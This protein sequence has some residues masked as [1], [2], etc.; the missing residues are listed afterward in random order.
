MSSQR[1]TTVLT[2]GVIALAGIFSFSLPDSLLPTSKGM[3]Q[4]G[5]PTLYVH[6]IVRD[7]KAD[8][9]D[10]DTTPGNGNGHY[11]GNIATTLDADNKPVFTGGGFKVDTQW[12]EG[13]NNKKICYTLYDAALGDTLG[14][15]GAPD[16]GGITSAETFAQWYRDV[17][18]V[19]MS[20]TY[21]FVATLQGD[22]TYAY[23]TNDFYPIDDQLLGNESESH[24]FY[25]TL[26]IVGTFVYDA[27]A[28]YTFHFKGDDD[29]WVFINGQLVVDLGG[30]AGSPEQFVGL[31]RLGLVDGET[32][33]LRFFSADRHAPQSK[34]WFSTSIGLET[35]V[36]PTVTAAFD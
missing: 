5:P 16:N 13:T 9:P 34:F 30:I 12:R 33:D 22:G 18:G 23:E 8:H 1:V 31:N 25:F 24:N 26:E 11:M 36:L 35:Y 7:F 15:A 2:Y 6:C 32:Y 28:N 4:A 3:L 21:S 10:F 19:N 20:K 29:V 14:V 17:P 27:A